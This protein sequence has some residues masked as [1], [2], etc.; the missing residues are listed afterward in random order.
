MVVS[1]LR[2]FSGWKKSARSEST[3]SNQGGRTGEI[4]NPHLSSD[5]PT[6]S[7]LWTLK[8]ETKPLP[9]PYRLTFGCC[10]SWCGMKCQLCLCSICVQN[11]VAVAWP[12]HG[13]TAGAACRLLSSDINLNHPPQQLAHCIQALGHFYFFHNGF[14]ISVLPCQT[15]WRV[16]KCEISK[17]GHMSTAYIPGF[18][19]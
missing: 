15:T 1:G 16:C 11:R 18:Y 19:T 13:P 9:D 10:R 12:S 7:G 17:W 3:R 14:C 4:R 2:T 5:C 8:T 6:S